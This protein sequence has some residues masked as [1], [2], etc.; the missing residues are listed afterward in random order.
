MMET[1]EYDAMRSL[2][3]A[4]WWYR[5][6]RS[7]VLRNLVPGQKILDAGCGTGGMLA[8]LG[9]FDPVGIDVSERAIAHSKGRGLGRLCRASACALP[10]RDGSFDAVLSLDV[11]YHRQVPDDAAAVA[12]CARVLRPGGTFLLHLPAYE[13]L[14]G[15]HDRATHGVRRYTRGRVR[16]L[17]QGAGLD[18]SVLTCRNAVAL[19]FAIVRRRLGAGSGSRDAHR[20]GSDLSRLPGPL[21]AALAFGGRLENAFLAVAPIPAGLSIWCRAVKPPRGGR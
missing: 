4:H 18:V 7:L 2:E 16:S 3:D 11:L 5:S 17:V 9:G 19:P 1:C 12:E 8:R 10:F 6:L 14:S 21:N 15:G 13:W 20:A